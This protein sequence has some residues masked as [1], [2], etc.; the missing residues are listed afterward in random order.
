[1]YIYFQTPVIKTF[2]PAAEIN[3]FGSKILVKSGISL[4]LRAEID[5][6]ISFKERPFSFRA[7]IGQFR[8]GFRRWIWKNDNETD[9]YEQTSFSR[10]SCKNS[11]LCGFLRNLN[12]FLTFCCQKTSIFREFETTSISSLCAN[13][14]TN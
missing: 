13:H 10:K 3:L 2:F 6:L 11:N 8:V 12:L 14:V 1:M 9:R 5:W 4:K 7:F